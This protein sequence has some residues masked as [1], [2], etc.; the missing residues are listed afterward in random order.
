MEKQ[1]KKRKSIF[2]P[3]R[4]KAKTNIERFTRAELERYRALFDEKIG[5]NGK[6]PGKKNG[7]GRMYFDWGIG[8]V[9]REAH[10]KAE[11]GVSLALIDH[12]LYLELWRRGIYDEVYPSKQN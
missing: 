10:S 3:R 12:R 8:E 6:K 11:D 4:R 9:I 5:N 1:V 7:N 2:Y